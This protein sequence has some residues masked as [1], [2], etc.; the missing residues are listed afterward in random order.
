MTARRGAVALL[1]VLGL[2]AVVGAQAPPRPPAPAPASPA[3]YRPAL[4]QPEFLEPFEPHLEPGRDAF[5]DEPNAKGIEA[6]LRRLGDAW[7]AGP[8][9][10]AAAAAWLLAPNSRGSEILGPD[11]KRPPADVETTRTGSTAETSHDREGLAREL[12]RVTAGARVLTTDFQV[13]AISPA[14]A[15]G[16]VG[17]EVRFDIVRTSPEHARIEDTGTWRMRWRNESGWKVVEWRTERRTSNRARRPLFTEVTT[18][19]LGGID[20]F[21]R[22]LNTPLDAWNGALDAVLTR[23]SNGHHGVSVGDAD[24][25]GLEDLYVAQPHG[26]P[27][28]LYRAKGDGTFED[29][30][31]RAGVGIL[32]DTAQSLFA[33]VDNDGDQ[34]L[35]LATGLQPLLFANDGKGR[36]TPVAGAFRF[37]QPLQGVLT[38]L[39]MADYDR[40]GFLDVY[41]CVYSYF[42]GAGEEKAGTPMPYHDARNGPPGV[43]FRNDGQG[44]FVDATKAT[45]L[46]AGNDRYHFAAAWADYDEDGWPDLLV[47][48]DFGT[49]NLYR[50]LGARG[51]AVTFEDVAAQAGVLDHG[52]GMSAAFFDYDNDGHLDI[53][54]GNMWTAE[55][56]RVT[57]SGNF[58]PKAPSD[59]RELYQR[60]TRGNG[61]FRNLGNGRFEDTTLAAGVN[62]GRWSWSSDTLDFNSDGWDDIYVANG[63]LTRDGPE[64]EGFFWRQVVAQS[65]LTPVKGTP[66]DEAWRAINQWL[67]KGSIASRQ[68]NVLFANDGKGAFYEVSGVAGL[69]L[70][71]DGRSFAVLDVDRDGDQDLAIMAARQTP[72]L[73]IFR[74]DFPSPGATFTLRLTG[75]AKS[76]RDAIGARVVV[77]TDRLTRTKVV[78]A[79]SGFLSQH[80]KALTFGLGPSEAIRKVSVTWPS[81][82]V[83][84]FTNAAPRTRA[85]L[86]EGGTLEVDAAAPAQPPAAPAATPVP[87]GAPIESWLYE[88]FPAP[89]FS[90]PDL[91][92]ETRS[93]SALAGK[94]ALLLFWTATDAAGRA[95]LD[96]LGRGRDTLAR[97][98]VAAIAVSL[99][100]AADLARVK[101]AAP[102]GLPVVAAP[103]DLAMSYALVNRHLFM[104]RQDL[105]LPTAFL[106]DGGGRIVKIYRERIDAARVASDAAAIDAPTPEARLARAIPFAGTFHA[107]LPTRNFLP[108]GRELMDQG[109]EAAAVVAFERAAQA[110][111]NASTLYRLGTLLARSGEPARARA[112]YERALALQPDLSEALN[113]LGALQAQAGDLDGAVA[114]FRAALV[115]TPDY[116]DALNNLG[117]ALL[118]MGRNEEARSLYERALA[119]QPDFPEALNNLGLL[120]GR[121]GDLDRAERFFRDALGRRATYGEAAGNLAL[122]LVN[123]GQSD[124]A[125]RLLEDF[126]AKV[127][128]YEGTYVTLARIHLSS[129]RTR[130]GLAILERLLQ[131]NPTHPV[132][133]EM[134]RQFRER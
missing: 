82:Q 30:T 41:L 126:L 57:A 76:N 67:I 120:Y 69:D 81:G 42:F 7:R 68:R 80:S 105:R 95:A 79:G 49:K 118:V 46:A 56:Q 90:V 83:Q 99:D 108:Y 97:A 3:I 133:L 20:S 15:A 5:I 44:G 131:R 60:H 70:E 110:N 72:H 61:L 91:A 92:G 21:R 32:D 114:R 12:T 35:V 52:A 88:P 62:M 128:A 34:D 13:I 19:A 130:Q 45:G 89:P 119:L 132:A 78:Q 102:A 122:V 127:P 18:A 50:N 14:T 54:T 112:A 134:L 73:R 100:A 84:T 16:V 58:M 101:Q 10:A 33:D 9:E 63:M 123:R 55:G 27:N 51:G 31:D 66:Y 37:D 107:A 38:G 28:R 47:A 75:S 116:P 25:D 96:A 17:A 71:Q 65:P 113:D 111:P 125:A 87:T 94:P 121:A 22:Q 59:V 6:Q 36:F 4:K 43:L 98:G 86:V 64:L 117:Y 77:E 129:G 24:G 53:Y 109:L 93:L 40:D 39:S 48:N 106:I 103:P 124:A 8:A 2:A 104:N 1:A 74:N 23:D 115:A 29:V 85:R 11:V 26:L